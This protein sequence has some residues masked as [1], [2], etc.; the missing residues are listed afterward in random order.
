ML[1][2]FFPATDVLLV[3]VVCIG[4]CYKGLFLLR[5]RTAKGLIKYRFKSNGGKSV[6]ITG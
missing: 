1:W 4:K 2:Y 5:F 6:K 3:T